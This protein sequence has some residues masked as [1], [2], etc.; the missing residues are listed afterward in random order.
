MTFK[1]CALA[2]ALVALAV[3]ASAHAESKSLQLAKVVLDTETAP[4]E[5]R[6][7]GGTLCVFPSN[8]ELPKE[9]KTQDFERYDRLVSEKLGKSEVAVVSD[10]GDLFAAESDDKG[11]ILLGAVMAPTAMNLCSSVKG[12][13]ETIDVKVEWQFYDRASSKVVETIVTEGS[14]TLAKFS[15][16]GFDEMWD[17]AF[18]DALGKVQAAGVIDRVLDAGPVEPVQA[19]DDPAEGSIEDAAPTVE[20]VQRDDTAVS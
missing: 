4:I 14:G 17:A 18:L 2:G 9:K 19:N 10:S 8:I 1:Q 12:F 3:P 16:S 5:A 11:D 20:A 6:V 13:K 7:K 15:A